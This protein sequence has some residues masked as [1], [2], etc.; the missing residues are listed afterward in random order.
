V[1]AILN[2]ELGAITYK[3]IEVGETKQRDGAQYHGNKLCSIIT[4]DGVRTLAH[5]N[6]GDERHCGSLSKM[7][8]HFT[9]NKQSGNQ[10]IMAITFAQQE[11]QAI[12]H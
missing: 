8:I 2:L 3:G 7:A 5:H 9:F 1:L 11:K 6:K 12:H 4:F 10:R